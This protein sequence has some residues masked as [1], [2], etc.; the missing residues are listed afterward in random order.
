MGSH[1]SKTDREY[2]EYEEYDTQG[3]RSKRSGSRKNSKRSSDKGKAREEDKDIIV[4][5][6]NLN[7]VDREPLDKRDMW[8]DMA[9]VVHSRNSS[10]V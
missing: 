5:D 3:S 6:A 8:G 2:E 4:R 9:R 10:N 1:S 7:I